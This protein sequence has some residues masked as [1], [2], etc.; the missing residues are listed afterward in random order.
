MANI[1]SERIVYSG[2][3]S[4]EALREFCKSIST[5]CYILWWV[6]FSNIFVF[7]YEKLPNFKHAPSDYPQGYFHNGKL[8]Q[9]SAKRKISAENAGMTRD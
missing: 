6:G 4:P 9:W 7:K 8:L 5:D 2:E 1:A 3:H